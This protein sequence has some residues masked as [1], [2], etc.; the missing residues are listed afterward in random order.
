MID[1]VT[2][3][4]NDTIIALAV[5]Y[6]A[7]NGLSGMAK[8]QQFSGTVIIGAQTINA[9]LPLAGFTPKFILKASSTTSDASAI[10]TL[11]TGSGIT[12]TNSGLG[13]LTA[14][15]PGT[16]LTTAATLWWRLDLTGSGPITD[17]AMYGKLAVLAV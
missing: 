5:N 11:T 16:D 2:Y 3:Q 13:Q 14:T 8:I 10:A 12:I 15:I 1:L 6:S 4:N 17:T 7:I 9:P